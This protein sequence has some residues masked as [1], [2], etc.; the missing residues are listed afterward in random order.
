M[1]NFGIELKLCTKLEGLVALV[2][3][4]HIS[5]ISIFSYEW[6]LNESLKNIFRTHTTAVSSKVLWK[7]A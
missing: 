2:I 6:S 5:V 7:I 4:K 1:K 3:S